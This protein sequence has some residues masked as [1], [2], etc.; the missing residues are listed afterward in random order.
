MA[1][2]AK[3]SVADIQALAD[4]ITMAASDVETSLTQLRASV[5]RDNEFQGTAAINYDEF[6]AA[7]HSHQTQMIQSMRDASSMLTAYAQR[8]DEIDDGAFN[9]R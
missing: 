6:L 3:S 4:K 8:L 2:S 1:F 5:A 7:W 9:T